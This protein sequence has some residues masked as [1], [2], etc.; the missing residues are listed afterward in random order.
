MEA[1]MRDDVIL[2][3][4]TLRDGEQTPG[5]A[6]P[7]ETKTRILDALIDAGIR[8]I[9][10]GI[11]AIGGDEL[12]FVHSVVDRQDEARLVAWHR[13]IAEELKSSLDLGFRTVHIGLPTSALHLSSS[14]RKDRAWLL[15]TARSLV[16]LAKDRGAFVS[17]SA[18]D[19]ARTDIGFLQEY[20]AVVQ[21]AGAD[22]L[23]L[24]DT[25]G[26]LTPESYG[27]R[28]AAVRSACDIDLQ[29]HAH[30]DFGLA[31]ANTLAGLRAGARYFHATVNGMGE[32]AGMVDLAQAV[33]TLTRLYGCS[34][35]VDAAKLRAL[36][37]TVASAAG[38]G[39]PPWQPITGENVFSHES[40]I[41]VSGMLRDSATFEPFPPEV[42]GGTRRYVLGKHS[43]RA[44]VRWMLEHEGVE[45]QEDLLTPCLAEVRERAIR[46]GG[47]V[48][49]GELVAVY[50]A[51]SA[52][53]PGRRDA[54]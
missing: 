11:P 45:P 10:V 17:I 18:E 29:C 30:N 27:K 33:L 54:P 48:S 40:G 24:S 38:H 6:F 39:L 47:A 26:L 2:E 43:G 37:A 25:V 44:L 49:P 12:R 52:A 15:A 8:W 35:G 19:L 46:S 53:G 50:Q 9:E 13:G 36:S 7:A 34:L 42:V 23:R 22:R 20:A 3:D 28:V 51:L 21:E 31:L 5:V 32:R 41:H 14:V 1:I 16:H 4:T